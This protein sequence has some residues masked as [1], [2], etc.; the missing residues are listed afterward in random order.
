MVQ[1][2]VSW[3]EISTRSRSASCGFCSCFVVLH[4][5][6]VLGNYPRK[7]CSSILQCLNHLLGINKCVK[8]L[9]WGKILQTLQVKLDPVMAV[10]HELLFNISWILK[11]DSAWFTKLNLQRITSDFN[12]PT[13]KQSCWKQNGVFLWSFSTGKSVDLKNTHFSRRIPNDNSLHSRELYP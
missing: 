5:R 11:H 9:D 12:L 1:I 7:A 4:S 3:S 13:L 2:Q 10:F 8:S 6:V